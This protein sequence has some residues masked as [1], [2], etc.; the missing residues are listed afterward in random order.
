M[1]SPPTFHSFSR[2][3]CEIRLQIW[4]AACFPSSRHHRGLHYIDIKYWRMKESTCRNWVIPLQEQGFGCQI[5]RS[6][7]IWDGGLWKTCKESR[8][9]IKRHLHVD[10]WLR[11]QEDPSR[12][13]RLLYRCKGD[14]VGAEEAVPPGKIT[15]L[16]CED[17]RDIVVHP[18]RDVFYIKASDWNPEEN[19][20]TP[21][22]V[23]VPFIRS[24]AVWCTLYIQNIAFEFDSNWISPFPES[25][26]CLRKESS[27][28]GLLATMLLDICRDYRCSTSNLWLIDKSARWV[29]RPREDLM[30]VYRDW[31]DEYV[32]V[33]CDVTDFIL[34]LGHWG[35]RALDLFGRVDDS[36]WTT[37]VPHRK[38]FEVAKSVRLVRRR[39][40]VTE[41][42]DVDDNSADWTARNRISQ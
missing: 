9:V 14:W 22:I 11:I 32:E 26:F 35:D 17:E 16:K 42:T 23:S 5:D 13:Y 30:T 28:R 2:L 31:D 34:D 18:A 6:A 1:A 41:F 7:Y 10:D 21:T 4:E 39:N 24:E 37:A 19:L 38:P 3:P 27:P 40:E 8:E 20:Y 15:A 12:E 33:G 29:R 25:I 36:H